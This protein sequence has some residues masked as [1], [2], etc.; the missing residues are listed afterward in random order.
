MFH[1]LVYQPYQFFKNMARDLLH[2]YLMN[3]SL[4][5][6][7]EVYIKEDFKDKNVMNILV[8]THNCWSSDYVSA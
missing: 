5:G 8:I 7:G 4:L 2:L 6:G 3:H 1:N